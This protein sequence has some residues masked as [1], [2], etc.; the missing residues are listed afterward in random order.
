MGRVRTLLI[1]SADA[2]AVTNPGE[3]LIASLRRGRAVLSTGPWLTL[4]VTDG[5]A[6]GLVGDEIASRSGTVEA[7]IAAGWNN[8]VRPGRVMLLVDGTPVETVAIDSGAA[9]ALPW[10]TAL[11]VTLARDG[12]LQAAFVGESVLPVPGLP[13]VAVTNPVFVDVGADGYAPHSPLDDRTDTQLVFARPVMAGDGLEPGLLT[14]RLENETDRPTSDTVRVVPV[15]PENI[16]I[17]PDRIDYTLRPHETAALTFEVSFPPEFLARTY[18][19]QSHTYVAQFLAVRTERSAGGVGRR[20]ATSVLE[21]DHPLTAIPPDTPVEELERAMREVRPM[22]T[23]NRHGPSRASL[24][25]ALCGDRLAVV[26]TVDDPDPKVSGATGAGVEVFTDM[27][28][29]RKITTVLLLPD[30]G[31]TPAHAVLERGGRLEPAADVAVYSRREGAGYV[32]SGLIPV[33]RTGLDLDH[34]RLLIEARVHVPEGSRYVPFT[35]MGNGAP[36][37]DHRPYPSFRPVFPVSAAWVSPAPIPIRSGGRPVPATLRLTNHSD[38][39]VTDALV[40]RPDPRAGVKAVPERAE[41]RIPAGAS[42]NVDWTLAAAS[43]LLTG[44]LEVKVPRSERGWIG[45]VPTLTVPVTGRGIPAFPDAAAA[46]EAPAGTAGSTLRDAQG[47][48]RGRIRLADLGESLLLVADVEDGDPVVGPRI[49]DGSVVELFLQPGGTGKITQVFLTPAADGQPA[50]ARIAQTEG[51][52][53]AADIAVRSEPVTGG[54]RIVATVPRAAYGL[55]GDAVAVEVQSSVPRA[56]GRGRTLLTA[57]GSRL[58]YMD[59]TFFGRF[60]IAPRE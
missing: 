21:I 10:R 56:D 39:D 46:L 20:P 26:A 31:G 51:P 53:E 17:S 40:C 54:Y 60:A 28:H 42:V 29:Q 15:P 48:A 14:V 13:E 45:L 59:A 32:L 24:R 33:T 55:G 2:A 50:A 34:N 30:S 12:F 37:A 43:E 9:A 41:V 57:F 47:T 23:K 58:A 3:R 11:P 25:F 27:T 5:E 1:E 8:G 7:T 19:V 52:E 49:W 18:P 4:T 36:H 16:R 6:T 22:P 44:A 38:R 35:I